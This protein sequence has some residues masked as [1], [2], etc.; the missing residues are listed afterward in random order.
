MKE[1]TKKCLEHDV[2]CPIEDCRLWIDFDEDLNCTEIAVA[3]N[4]RMTLRQVSERIGVSFVR[5]KQ[6]EDSLKETGIILSDE[7]QVKL[8]E[9][10]KDSLLEEVPINRFTSFIGNIMAARI[11]S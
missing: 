6:I 4:G 1:C 10:A 8:I 11:S 5:I 2:S 3:K 9:L 7:E